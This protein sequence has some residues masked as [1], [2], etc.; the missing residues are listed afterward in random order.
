MLKNGGEGKGCR[1]YT[2]CS[3]CWWSWWFLGRMLILPWRIERTAA[4]VMLVVVVGGLRS[5]LQRAKNDKII[6]KTNTRTGDVVGGW[7][8]HHH[9]ICGIIFLFYGTLRM[10]RWEYTIHPHFLHG[11]EP[12]MERMEI[13]RNS[14]GLCVVV[15]ISC[16]ETIRIVKWGKSHDQTR[17]GLGW[18]YIKSIMSY[19]SR[20]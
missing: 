1:C 11:V 13:S 17:P 3:G 7:R 10:N 5:R 16:G 20:V 8:C 6:I 14:K 4:V 18:V 2:Y 15:R 19:I 9:N 12:N